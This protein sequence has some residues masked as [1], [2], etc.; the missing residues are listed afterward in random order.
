M[1]KP[2]RESVAEDYGPLVRRIA[3]RLKKVSSLHV[4]IDELVQNGMIGLLGA[5]DRFDPSLGVPFE[6]YA[7]YRVRGAMIDELRNVTGLTRSEV[8]KLVRLQAASDTVDGYT[9]PEAHPDAA[10]PSSSS[11]FAG[12][13]HSLEIAERA[14]ASEAFDAHSEHLQTPEHIVQD[15]QRSDELKV[16]IGRLCEEDRIYITEHYFK[17]RPLAAIARDRNVSRSWACRIHARAVERLG[18]ILEKMRN[19]DTTTDDE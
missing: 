6:A 5:W 11:I 14:T 15:K 19:G 8:R 16:A 18:R 2:D 3:R 4:E 7:Y 9:S 10:N 17:E 13:V 12:V 1:R